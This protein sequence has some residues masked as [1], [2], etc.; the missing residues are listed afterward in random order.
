MPEKRQ[1]QR[2]QYN[3]INENRNKWNNYLLTDYSQCI[4]CKI[5]PICGGGCPRELVHFGKSSRCS[6]LKYNITELMEVCALNIL[7]IK[8]TNYG[9]VN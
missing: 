3:I 8:E 6:P 2:K 1:V 4:D 9:N 7:N 5:L